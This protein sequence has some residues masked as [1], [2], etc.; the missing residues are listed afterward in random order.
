MAE[1]ADHEPFPYPLD[2]LKCCYITISNMHYCNGMHIITVLFFTLHYGGRVLFSCTILFSQC[3]FY[4]LVVCTL[5]LGP[6]GDKS[7][8]KKAAIFLKE[9]LL[10]SVLLKKLKLLEVI[11][12]YTKF[13]STISLFRENRFKSFDSVPLG[14]LYF[15]ILRHQKRMTSQ[16]FEQKIEHCQLILQ[17]ILQIAHF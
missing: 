4:F 15:K 3:D 12:K 2:D 7:F 14:T 11:K 17:K 9:L 13:C 6:K 16:N 10:K 8:T 1:N 5:C